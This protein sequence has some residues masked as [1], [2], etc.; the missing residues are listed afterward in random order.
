MFQRM[1]YFDIKLRQQELMR[2][3]EERRRIPRPALLESDR[4]WTALRLRFSLAR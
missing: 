3:A 1:D 4:S 2:E